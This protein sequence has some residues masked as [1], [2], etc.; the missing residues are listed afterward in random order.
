[1]GHLGPAQNQLLGIWD[2]S[3]LS[4]TWIRQPPP[5]GHQGPACQRVSLTALE[6]AGSKAFPTADQVSQIQSTQP[7]HTT[8]RIPISGAG[9]SLPRVTAL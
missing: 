5:P 1:M 9:H 3:L 4:A 7:S 6:G 8:W 2:V